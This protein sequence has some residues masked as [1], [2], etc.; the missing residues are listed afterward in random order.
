[1][2][3]GVYAT[4]IGKIYDNNNIAKGD[5]TTSSTDNKSIMREQYKPLYANKF[6]N[7]EEMVTFLEW[8]KL[9]KFTQEVIDDSNS[10]IIANEIKLVVKNHY[11]VKAPGP[12]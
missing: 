7:W 10:P 3:Y 12:D 9:P 1:M 5:I 2:C 6:N 11:T 4:Y 8:P